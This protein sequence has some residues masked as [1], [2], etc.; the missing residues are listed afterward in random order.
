MTDTLTEATDG[1]SPVKRRAIWLIPIGLTVVVLII[2]GVIV[3]SS[4]SSGVTDQQQL[5]SVQRVC[6]EW[7]GSSAVSLGTSSASAAC[8][9]MAEWM[10]QQLHDGQ[11]TG[12]LF[13]ASG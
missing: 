3:F 6:G 1:S 11:M 10:G 13:A 12:A 4:D 7:S 8:S 2:A 9:T 5:A